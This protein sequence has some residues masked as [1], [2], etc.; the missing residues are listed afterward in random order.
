VVGLVT[1]TSGSIVAWYEDYPI[2]IGHAGVKYVH[3]DHLGRPEVVTNGTGVAIWRSQNFAFDRNVTLDLIGELSLGFPGQ[4]YDE[5]NDLWSNGYRQ[6]DAKIGRYLQSDPVG[7]AD[8]INTYTYVKGNPVNSVDPLGLSTWTGTGNASAGGEIGNG[9]L[10][11]FDLTSECILGNRYHIA[12]RAWA[13]GFG[14]GFGPA[15]STNFEITLDDQFTPTE[16]T[17]KTLGQEKFDRVIWSQ[18]NGLFYT[19]GAG[20]TLGPMSVGPTVFQFGG[21]NFVPV[22]STSVETT[23]GFELPSASIM[24]GHA[25][26][27]GSVTKI[28]CGCP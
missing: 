19:A 5:D 4:Y 10:Y 6:Y 27:F 1:P 8:G 22:V 26:V 17:L 24:L 2:T 11:L 14:I 23:G 9:G 21:D 7:L 12:V 16:D 13:L 28:P 3:N 15:G 25:E 18:F 20:A